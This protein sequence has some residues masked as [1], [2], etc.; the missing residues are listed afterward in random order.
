MAAAMNPILIPGA[1][2]V[3]VNGIND[4]GQIVRNFVSRAGAQSFVAAVPS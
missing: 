4:H 1:T 3:S 2:S